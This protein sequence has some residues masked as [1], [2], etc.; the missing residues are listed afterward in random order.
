MKT[1]NSLK[2]NSKGIVGKRTRKGDLLRYYWCPGCKW[3]V[4]PDE[5]ETV[6][7]NRVASE[8]SMRI[9]EDQIRVAVEKFARRLKSKIAQFDTEIETRRL[10][11]NHVGGGYYNS[12]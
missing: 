5:I 12:Q 6:V 9:L 8:L 4:D 10:Q 1:P 3:W 11:L 7:I 2:P